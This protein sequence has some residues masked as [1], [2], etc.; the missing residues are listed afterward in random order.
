MTE[1]IGVEIDTSALSAGLGEAGVEIAR[2]AREEIAPAAALIEDAFAGAASSIERNLNRAARSGALSFASLGAA[3]ARD[4][5]RMAVDSLVRRPVQSLL[6][7]AFAAPFAGA[8]S[9]GGFVAPGGAYLVG[10]RGP[11]LFSPGVSGR[12]GASGPAR[13]VTVNIAVSGAASPDSFR[14]SETQI[15]AGLA[16]ALA[17]A[18]RN[19]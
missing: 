4:L 7:N 15:A 5:R 16:R 6:S 8:R 9:A 13:A 10:E 3:L 17:R 14:Q 19:A 11:E 12:I 2:M 18:E 1:R